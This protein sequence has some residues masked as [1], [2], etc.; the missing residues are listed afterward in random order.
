MAENQVTI[1]VGTDLSEVEAQAKQ[2]GSALE[3]AAKGG[4]A[5]FEAAQQRVIELRKSIGQLRDELLKTQ[6]PARVTVINAALKGQSAELRGATMNLKAM[7]MESRHTNEHVQMLAASLGVR[8]PYGLE[9]ILARLPLVQAAMGAA[10]GVGIIVAVGAAII[11]IIP[12]LDDWIDKLRGIESVTA[13]VY[14]QVGK[15]N[16]F[17]ASGGHPEA[18]SWLRTS[19]RNVAGDIYRVEA[20][21]K[22]LTHLQVG[23]EA[24]AF[25]P[26]M[27][28]INRKEV[29]LLNEQLVNLKKRYEEL[30]SAI[31][32]ADVKEHTKATEETAKAAKK[33]ADAAEQWQKKEAQLKWELDQ[34]GGALLK[35]KQMQDEEKQAVETRTAAYEAEI[36][37]RKAGLKSLPPLIE[38]IYAKYDILSDEAIKAGKD[39]IDAGEKVRHQAEQLASS[40]ESFIDRVFMHARSL[41]EV[42]HQLLMQMLGSFVKWVSR[43]IAQAL[44][45]MKTLS[46]AQAG[47]GGGGILGLLLGGLFGVGGGGATALAATAGVG[48]GMTAQGLT[49]GIESMFTSSAGALAGGSALL[50]QGVGGSA[51]LA[52]GAGVPGAAGGASSG[53]LGALAFGKISLAQAMA[54]GGPMAMLGGAG[55]MGSA[56]R[57]GGPV[58][59]ALGGA[60]LGV[61]AAA[62]M[63]GLG[64]SSLMGMA[65]AALLTTPYGWLALA[66]IAG[67][68][69]LIGA[70][71]RNKAKR[72]ASALEQGFELAAN[73]LYDQFK[74]FQID[75]ENA[76]SGMQELITQGQQ[77]LTSSG[78][79]RWGRQGAQNLTTVIQDEIQALNQL[80]RQRQERFGIMAGRPVPEF[81]LGGP[82]LSDGFQL[83]SRGMLAILHPNEWVLNERQVNAL[84]RS[85]LA[86]LP[87]FDSGGAVG[88]RGMQSAIGQRTYNQTFNLYQLPAESQQVF[89]N[90][91]VRAV[92]RATGD[93]QL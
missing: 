9:R 52:G 86:N 72:K 3:G 68:G 63:A 60:M 85:F 37:T 87:R 26:A 4:I 36:A 13:D 59:G 61:G 6:D 51:M 23:P 45:G 81:A 28:L 73:E 54:M 93:G 12:K 30:G 43:M 24:G 14:A 34:T 5:G 88:G 17:L 78:Y 38:Q 20:D 64:G 18:L 29:Y 66:A 50:S 25:S 40:I 56:G 39:Q 62:T 57:A 90:R 74:K 27:W 49:T 84:G 41:S 10:F 2:M 76:L 67:I 19:I 71:G 82:V 92:R 89:V 15:L 75:Y 35:V 22:R 33:A 69:A 42:F 47:G 80:Q 53:V 83:P 79:G 11:A 32:T 31:P 1:K 44:L 48:G 8:I 46:G 70:A 91:V 55:L 16:D 7:G 21:I 77:T 65:G 58:T